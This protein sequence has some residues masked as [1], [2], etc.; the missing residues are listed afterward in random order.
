MTVVLAL[1]AMG[2]ERFAYYGTRGSLYELAMRDGMPTSSLNAVVALLT[3]VGVLVG[4][5]LAFALGPRLTGVV[6]GVL[7]AAGSVACV[8]LGAWGYA[9]LAFGAGMFRIVPIAVILEELPSSGGRFRRVAAAVAFGGA[10]VSLSAFGSA[11]FSTVGV[12][13]GASW[14]FGLS[15]LPFLVAAALSGVLLAR[16]P[17]KHRETDE[18]VELV[19]GPSDDP[20]RGG[21]TVRIVRPLLEPGVL[22]ALLFAHVLVSF[23]SVLP[24]APLPYNTVLRTL[25]SLAA[26]AAAATLGAVFA[27]GAA[28]ARSTRIFGAGLALLAV[29]VVFGVVTRQLGPLAALFGVVVTCGHAI[30]GTVGI[31]AFATRLPRRFGALGVAFWSLVPS[32]FVFVSRLLPALSS[33]DGRS[34]P[35]SVLV[36]AVG[37]LVGGVA[38]ALLAFGGQLQPNEDP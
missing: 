31:A 22:A 38:V 12:R 7:A 16:G 28:R 20:Y 21:P 3:V 35:M 1:L 6:A 30:V 26:F 29:G 14:V 18:R 33:P 4:G 17:R 23:V 13:L 25:D 36:A 19:P 8:V 24:H 15:A 9:L 10:T 27:T 32:G 5:V 37:L 2:A 11:L 34:S